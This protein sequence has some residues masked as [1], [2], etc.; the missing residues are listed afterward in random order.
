MTPRERVLVAL[1]HQKPDKVPLFVGF[2]TSTEEGVLRIGSMSGKDRFMSWL[3]TD[4]Y[5]VVLKRLGIDIREVSIL[6]KLDPL[7]KPENLP[8]DKSHAFSGVLR[9]IEDPCQLDHLYW[10]SFEEVYEYNPVQL[11]KDIQKIKNLP[12]EYAICC[13]VGVSFY[14]FSWYLRG[15]DKLLMDLVSNPVMACGIMDRILNINLQMAEAVLGEIG[16]EIDFIISGDDFG[17]QDRLIMSPNTFRKYIKPR[18]EKGHR[19]I[20]QLTGAYIE[21]HSC[22][23]VYEIIPDLIEVGI[24]ILNPVQPLARGMDRQ[25]LKEEFGKYLSF[26]G[27][28]DTQQVL[29]Y[30]T[31]KEVKDE[32]LLCFHTLGKDGGYIMGPSHDLQPDVPPENIITMYETAINECKYKKDEK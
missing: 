17:M 7:C 13:N 4:D 16:K 23:T 3:R 10:P 9:E 1:A 18:L 31:R 12:E 14:E 30:G 29:P 5:E 20:R 2:N 24:Q 11:K 22:G 28:V 26:R 15:Q 8:K 6:L 19:F 32:V 27:G 21:Y 25:R